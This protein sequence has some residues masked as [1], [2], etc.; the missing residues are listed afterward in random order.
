V[1]IQMKSGK[2]LA[3]SEGMAVIGLLDYGSQGGQVLVIA[4][5]G[6]LQVDDSARNLEF[7]RNIA[8]YA[9]WRKN[10]DR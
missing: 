2:V 6:L 5:L 1:P 8:Q 9:R 7:I 10:S 4:D 3:R